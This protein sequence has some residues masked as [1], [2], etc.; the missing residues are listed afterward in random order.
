MGN[1]YLW[2]IFIYIT[3]LFVLNSVATLSLVTSSTFGELLDC[4]V[5]VA[6]DVHL[7]IFV[8]FL[9]NNKNLRV[10]WL[11]HLSK[12][13][14]LRWVTDFNQDLLARN[15]SFLVFL[16]GKREL[17]LLAE[18]LDELPDLQVRCI[19]GGRGWT[20]SYRERFTWFRCFRKWGYTPISHPQNHHF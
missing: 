11:I 10:L 18:R 12:R 7:A 17:Q 3:H 2:C 13:I 8:K 16:P 14:Q 19:F 1:I 5:V 9:I 6:P 15:G 4:M 20:E